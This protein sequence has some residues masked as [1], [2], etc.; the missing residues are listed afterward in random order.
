[1]PEYIID[2]EETRTPAD[3]LLEHCSGEV[4]RCRDC[5]FYMA[6]KGGY[7]DVFTG[8]DWDPYGYCAWGERRGS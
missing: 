1:M 5:R 7:C 2:S 3:W 6:G 4:V 8:T